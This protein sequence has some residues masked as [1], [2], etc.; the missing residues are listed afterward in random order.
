M[1]EP[2]AEEHDA[3]IQLSAQLSLAV[4]SQR[5][6]QV[7]PE[8]AGQRNMPAPP[9]FLYGRA[10][11]RMIKV[12][13]KVEAEHMTQSDCHIR[14]PG[15]VKVYLKTVAYRSQPCCADIQLIGAD[16]EDQIC[17]LPNGIGEQQLF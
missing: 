15:E 1:P 4:A 16:S 9:E 12:F 11:V 13:Q 14:V 7:V 10:D 3:F 2:C 17:H 6:V 5:D 8:P